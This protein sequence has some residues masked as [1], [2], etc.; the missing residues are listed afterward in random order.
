MAERGGQPGNNNASKGRPWRDA[1]GRALAKKSRVE[2]IE[3]LDVIAEKVVDAA[4]AGP[5][6]EKGDPWL[7][8]I[9]ELADRLDG[10]AAQQIQLSGDE[11][12][13]LKIVHESK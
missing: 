10:K 6:H 2:Q 5:S 4:L 11:D 1:I 12:S 3:A 13:P 7:S 9:H 8:A